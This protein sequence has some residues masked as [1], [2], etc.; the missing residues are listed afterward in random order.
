MIRRVAYELYHA[1]VY[2]QAGIV[3]DVRE[4]ITAVFKAPI[5]A[6]FVIMSVC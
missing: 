2:W 4:D 3:R 5:A 6:L 1:G